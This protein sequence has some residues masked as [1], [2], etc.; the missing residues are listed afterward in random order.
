MEKW[1]YHNIYLMKSSSTINGLLILLNSITE[2]DEVWRLDEVDF[3]NELHDLYESRILSKGEILSFIEKVDSITFLEIS[4]LLCDNTTV[5][6]NLYCFDTNWVHVYT[7][8]NII[9]NLFTKYL[10]ENGLGTI[11]CEESFE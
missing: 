11:D 4:V 6:L 2:Q 9:M 1:K 10:C 7:N 3:F 5:K 8:D